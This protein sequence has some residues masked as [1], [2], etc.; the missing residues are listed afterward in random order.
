MLYQYVR[1]YYSIRT[2]VKKFNFGIKHTYTPIFENDI[3]D[4]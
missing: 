4:N 2:F 3:T 1:T